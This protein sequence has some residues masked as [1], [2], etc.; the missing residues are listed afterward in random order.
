MRIAGYEFDHICEIDPVRDTDGS[1]RL[2]MPQGRYKKNAQNLPLNRYGTGPFCKLKIANRIRASGVYVLTV[3]EEVRYVGNPAI[4]QPDLIW[5]TET[6]PPRTALRAAR[7]RI[8][9]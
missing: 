9:A 4:S 7:K 8:A 5:A 6:F 1:V 3:G 2:F